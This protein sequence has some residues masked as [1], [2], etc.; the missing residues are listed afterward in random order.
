MANVVLTAPDISCAHCKRNIES[1]LST[2][3]G[4]RSVAVDVDA[5]SVKVEFDERVID[6]PGIRSALAESGYPPAA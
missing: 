2:A 6:E 4:V 1:D 5:K 3:S